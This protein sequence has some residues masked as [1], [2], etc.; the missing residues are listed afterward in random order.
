VRL[1]RGPLG[2]QTYSR[3]IAA[4]RTDHGVLIAI[5]CGAEPVLVGG[6]RFIAWLTAMA[7]MDELRVGRILGLRGIVLQGCVSW[8]RWRFAH[9]EPFLVVE[10]RNALF[11]WENRVRVLRTRNPHDLDRIGRAELEAVVLSEFE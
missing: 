4:R 10:S 1:R 9:A 8:L 5:A 6:V 7:T 3:Q 11:V 2:Q